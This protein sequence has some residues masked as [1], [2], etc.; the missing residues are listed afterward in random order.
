M[1][2]DMTST[3]N[4]LKWK[5][6]GRG[7]MVSTDGRYAVQADGYSR[8]QS[9]SASDD[10]DP[11][12]KIGQYEGFPGGEWAAIDMSRPDDNLDWFPTMREAKAEC[13]RHARR[14]VT[15]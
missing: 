14:M 1:F 3:E 5:R 12:R 15:A 6:D 9:V 8:I 7:R 13:E 4:I 10:W 2:L 11:K